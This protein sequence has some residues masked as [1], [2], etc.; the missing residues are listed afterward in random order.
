MQYSTMVCTA[1]KKAEPV[2]IM[3]AASRSCFAAHIRYTHRTSAGTSSDH[4]LILVEQ[5]LRCSQT[6]E[7]IEPFRA[8]SKGYNDERFAPL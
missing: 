6:Q 7:A 1:N 5:I 3:H 8:A 4:A 2:K